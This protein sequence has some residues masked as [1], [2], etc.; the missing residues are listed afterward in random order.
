MSKLQREIEFHENRFSDGVGS[1]PQDKFYV[2]VR[3]AYRYSDHLVAQCVKAG[4][5][6]LDVGC[7]VGYATQ[8]LLKIRPFE[9]YGIDVS[10]AAI[11]AARKRFSGHATQPSFEVM[12]AN[13]MTFPNQKFDFIFGNGVIHHL[14]LPHSLHEA[15]RV[16]KDGGRFVFTEPLGT[17]PLIN[18]YRRLTP[19]DRSPDETPLTGRHL[20]QLREVFGDVRLQ[21]FGLFTLAGIALRRWP[22]VQQR[23]IA[24]GE[25]ADRAVFSIPGAWRLAWM[26]V[27][28]ARRKGEAGS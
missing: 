14:E 4:G 28:D 15:R 7:S 2:A 11:E 21:Y 17:N 8:K 27:I 12:D 20:R 26:V 1:R 19:N 16:L 6:G 10:L 25:V 3:A 13:H 23:V 9:A 5:A 18:T 22:R 24:L